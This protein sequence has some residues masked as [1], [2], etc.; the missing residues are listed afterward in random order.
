MNPPQ[1]FKDLRKTDPVLAKKLERKEKKK[2]SKKRAQLRNAE[3][4]ASSEKILN[5]SVIPVISDSD[6]LITRDDSPSDDDEEKTEY[7][8]E[9]LEDE[10]RR[11]RAL[12]S[13]S[14]HHRRSNDFES[15]RLP[16]DDSTTAVDDDCKAADDFLVSEFEHVFDYF[17]NDPEEEDE[18]GEEDDSSVADRFKN[19]TE[20]KETSNKEDDIDGETLTETDGGRNPKKFQKLVNRPT[21]SALKQWTSRPDVVEFWDTTS[22]DPQ[23]LVTMKSMRN[24]VPVPVHWSHKRKYLQGKKGFEKPAFRL[25]DYIE[26]TKISEIRQ[27]IQEKESQKTLK[28]KMR[29]KVHPKMHKMDIDYQTL[30][31]A[32][33]KYA[34]R[35]PMRPQGDLYY[36]GKE[37]EIRMRKFKIGKLS[38]RLLTALGLSSESCPPPYL[39]NMQRYGPP[40]AY[41]NVGVPGVNAPIPIGAS[42][43]F[44][45][46]GWG[47]PSTDSFG[48]LMFPTPLANETFYTGPE[49]KV[50]G[51]LEQYSDH[52]EETGSQNEDMEDVEPE[53]TPGIATPAST[54]A[55]TLTPFDG[56]QSASGLNSIASLSSG[57]GT[58]GSVD[59]R[60]ASSS[61]TSTASSAKPYTILRE[62]KAPAQPGSFFASNTI[63]QLPTHGTQTPIGLGGTAT[64][65]GL[66]PGGTVTPFGLSAP[67]GMVTPLG[68]M[69]GSVTPLLTQ[70]L[71]T[72]GTVQGRTVAI[73]P[74]L[75]EQEGVFAGDIIRQ[76]LLQHEAAKTRTLEAAGQ[77]EAPSSSAAP[78]PKDG[79]K[80]KK[81]KD[82][83]KF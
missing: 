45:P 59:I 8:I 20:E 27:V 54:I 41:P 2:K 35:P 74:S 31:D 18:W 40:P 33:F 56:M 61:S 30:H 82:S 12:N 80:K 79:K 11:L 67:L 39:F 71:R 17:Q 28:Q 47:Q 9:T 83:F 64:P 14:S 58:P 81:G 34:T 29:E 10:L 36:E 23:L 3:Y 16:S 22:P 78:K 50:W 44:H 7:V 57:L 42:Y 19:W 4:K 66:A 75:I 60:A 48:N 32:F 63:Y 53:E 72:P 68:A 46:T 51:E 37:L 24:S 52:E 43:G 65:M 49:S 21:V 6:T 77:L 70:G 13:S 1:N 76:Q 62:Q 73:N 5:S 55:G 25:P 69:G 38:E 26:A 15:P